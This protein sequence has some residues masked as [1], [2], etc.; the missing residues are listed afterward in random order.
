VTGPTWRTEPR[1]KRGQPSPPPAEE[2]LVSTAFDLSRMIMRGSG[3]VVYHVQG[4]GLVSV[5]QNKTK[6][7]MKLEIWK[8]T[9]ME[10]D[11]LCASYICV[12]CNYPTTTITFIS[13]VQHLPRYSEEVRAWDADTEL[14]LPDSVSSPSSH[15]SHLY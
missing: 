5:L 4:L 15:G 8:K 13:Q 1:L 10:K 12:L 2:P 3:A 7:F 9:K 14:G 6:M 11:L